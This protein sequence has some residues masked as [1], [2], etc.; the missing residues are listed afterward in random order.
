MFLKKHLSIRKEVL[1]S[2]LVFSG[3]ALVVFGALFFASFG[4]TS[5]ERAKDSLR[6]TNIKAGLITEAI[7]KEIYNTVEILASVPE[8]ADL[9]SAGGPGA[10]TALK[11]Y[12]QASATNEDIGYIYS[13]YQDGSLLIHDYIPPEGYNSTKRPWYI[14]ALKEKPG[15][16]FG[17]PYRE[18]STNEWLISQS[19]ALLDSQGEVKGVLAIDVFLNRTNALLEKEKKYFSQQSFALGQEGN[20]IIHPESDMIGQTI[21]QIAQRLAG[22]QGQ[23]SFQGEN[24]KRW[25][26]YNTIDKVD[27]TVITTVECSEVINPI[28][29]RTSVYAVFIALIAM[30]LAMLQSWYFGRRIADPLIALGKRVSEIVESKPRTEAKYDKSNHEIATIAGNIEE[31]TQR[32]LQ[33]KAN[34]LMTI[35]A[36][37][38]D[39]ILVV[40]KNRKVIYI[41]SRFQKMWKLPSDIIATREDE[42]LIQYVLDQLKSPEAFYDKV[43][44]LYVSGWDDWDT[45]ML[46]DGRIFELLSCPIIN[47]GSVNGTFWSFRDVTEKKLAEE[48]LQKMATI[49]SLTGLFNRQSFETELTQTLAHIRRYGRHT[50]L[51]MFDVDHFKVIYD[52]Y[53]HA[54]GDEVLKE[55]AERSKAVLREADFLVRWGGEEFIVILPETDARA[56]GEATE[57]LR[58]HMETEPFF[59]VGRITISL[60]VTGILPTDT[61][62]SLLKRLDDA[63]YESKRLGRNRLVVM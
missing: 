36:S 58:R 4:I 39:G 12:I 59:S 35:I 5:I 45:I 1:Y 54:A 20:A 41:N 46:K 8:I 40:D 11:V 53:G 7:F 63:L 30:S 51:V 55:L 38:W 9:T 19:K 28:L 57:R 62:D 52:N 37:S 2:G 29:L 43:N 22:E 24:G 50:S 14:S 13:G 15:Q 60:G 21:T 48:K 6:E 47:E 26:F 17:L 31:L 16:S 33:R 49:D 18:A 25:A 61:K 34:E 44:E 27:W 42:R 10:G 23:F 3:A 56:A 32:A